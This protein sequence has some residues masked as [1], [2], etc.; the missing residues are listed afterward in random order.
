MSAV[1]PFILTGC[2]TG[3][4][5]TPKITAREV[6]RRHAVETPEMIYAS[7]LA[8]EP[9]ARWQAGKLFYVTD[10]KISYALTPYDISVN[11]HNGDLLTYQGHEP[12]KSMTEIDDT[13]FIFTT[14]AGDTLRYRVEAPYDEI[15][16]RA[17]LD[18]PF[19]IEMS[20]V[21]AASRLL[22]GNDYYITTSLWFN[23]NGD[24]INGR[25][26][27]KVHID[28]VT[29]GNTNY[30]LAVHFTDGRGTSSRVYMSTGNG[31]R[32][33]RNFDTLF[34][35]TD[36]REKYRY[37]TDAIWD[38]ITRRAVCKEMTREEC[39]L[40]VGNPVEVYRGHYIE[41]WNYDNGRY[42]IFDD[43]HLQEFRF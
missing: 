9:P 14:A 6:E 38:Y 21:E 23:D 10:G 24:N 15:A 4:E 20:L 30:L 42:L 27:V 18:V 2:F 37:I 33:T 1:C 35:L 17:S 19:T 43:D 26:L 34:T 22:S 32:S 29:P 39:R 5:S 28:S 3:V 25:Q 12:V 36:P 16:G 11:L 13:D 7:P 40:A 41:R 8:V 31:A